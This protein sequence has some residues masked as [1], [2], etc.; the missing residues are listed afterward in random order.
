MNGAG[1]REL[2]SIAG[3]WWLQ[4]DTENLVT[5]AKLLLVRCAELVLCYSLASPRLPTSSLLL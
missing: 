2:L 1:G 5:V 4:Q 3:P